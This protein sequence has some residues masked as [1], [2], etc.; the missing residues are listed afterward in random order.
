MPLLAKGIR[1]LTVVGLGEQKQRIAKEIAPA[2]R[3]LGPA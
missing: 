1:F 3:S 2:L